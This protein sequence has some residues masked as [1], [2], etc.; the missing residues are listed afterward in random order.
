MNFVYNSK[1]PTPPPSQSTAEL[2]KVSNK[3]THPFTILSDFHHGTTLHSKKRREERKR[4][5]DVKDGKQPKL[6]ENRKSEGKEQPDADKK[7]RGKILKKQKIH[8]VNIG[9]TVRIGHINPRGTLTPDKILS[10]QKLTVVQHFC[11]EVETGGHGMTGW[12][13][14]D[15]TLKD[16]PVRTQYARF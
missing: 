16:M 5:H 8:E 14:A 4:E 3:Q 15:S 7:T 10:L 11:N 1:V 6:Q 13:P 12:G 9:P 2:S